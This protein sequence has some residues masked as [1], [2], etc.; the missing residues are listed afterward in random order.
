MILR[1]DSEVTQAQVKMAPVQEQVLLSYLT[2]HIV[3]IL[4]LEF[5]EKSPI[6]NDI[7]SRYTSWKEHCEKLMTIQVGSET[8][9]FT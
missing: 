4:G 2:V 5:F 7:Y 6:K 1:Y 8:G 3:L 9:N